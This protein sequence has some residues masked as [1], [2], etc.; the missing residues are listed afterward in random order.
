MANSSLTSPGNAAGEASRFSEIRGRLAFMIAGLVV[1]RIGTFIPVPGI[2][3]DAVT[4]FFADQTGLLQIANMFSGGAL[5]R[6]SIFAMGVMPYISASII[7]QMMGM[8]VPT[9]MEL[10]KEGESGRRKLTEYTRYGT[11]VLAAFQSF[12]AAIALQANHMVLASGPMWLLTATVT[13]DH[14]DAVP[15][16]AGRADHRAW[17]RQRHLDADSLRHRR[18]PSRRGGQYLPSRSAPV[19]CP[20]RSSCCC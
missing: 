20:V 14:R 6:L 11:V 9:L 2:N 7:I 15:D 4:R 3:P 12:A 10:R 16:V 8:V 19:K 1:Y 5:Q 18:R 13:H 17:H